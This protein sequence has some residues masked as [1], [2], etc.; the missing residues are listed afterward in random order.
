MLKISTQ[1]VRL[2]VSFSSADG[3]TCALAA[4]QLVLRSGPSRLVASSGELAPGPPAAAREAA[5]PGALPRGSPAQ[6]DE[7]HRMETKEA[8]E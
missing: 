3:F 8:N 4:F 1:P 7:R 2:A 5:E 6:H